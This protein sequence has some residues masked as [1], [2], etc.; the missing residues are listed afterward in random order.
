MAIYSQC[1][2]KDYCS[3]CGICPTCE[4]E[5][6][7]HLVENMSAVDFRTPIQ[8][9]FGML[10]LLQQSTMTPQ[11]A[12]YIHI[13]LT[14]SE[15]I[16]DIIN[17]IPELSECQMGR[18]KQQKCA[19]A[20]TR[21]ETINAN[22]ASNEPMNTRKM[23]NFPQVIRAF[24]EDTSSNI[25][26]IEKTIFDDWDMALLTD[27]VQ[28]LQ[29][30]ASHLPAMDFIAACQ[31]LQQAISSKNNTRVV[32]QWYNVKQ[33]FDALQSRLAN[34]ITLKAVTKPLQQK[35]PIVLIGDDDRSFRLVLRGALENKNY[36]II[37]AEN[38][39]DVIEACIEQ[40][41]DVVLLDIKMPIMDG[42][43]ACK[44]ILKLN[45]KNKPVILM[46]SSLSDD[47]TKKKSLAA[48]AT[49]FIE[50]PI[51]TK[52]MVDHINNLLKLRINNS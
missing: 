51:D 44:E 41:P 28:R 2:C 3:Y 31:V 21:V 47:E 43:T 19:S 45:A 39:E 10:E 29:G 18:I 17:T 33:T 40:P 16:L 5:Y 1:G 7:N 6:K 24:I 15:S 27:E 23:K 22:S 42:Y 36:Q 46:L 9:I 35:H 38:G 50:K 12:N 37:Q 52:I 11:Q 20:E 32:T 26:N 25:K 48:G 49:G 34:E 8:N 30:S 13:A 4:L 14:S